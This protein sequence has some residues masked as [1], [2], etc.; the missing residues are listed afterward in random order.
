MAARSR[1]SLALDT[2]VL[3]DLADGSEVA[4]DFREV[5]QRKGYSLAAPPTAMFELAMHRA[6]GDAR[7]QR[8]ADLA[9]TRLAAWRIVP[10]SFSDVE[11]AIADRFAARLIELGLLPEEEFSDGL[12]LAE[13]A[14]ARIPVVVSS[15]KHL[16]DIEPEDLRAALDAADLEQVTVM[17]PHKLLRAVL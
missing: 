2:N 4:H 8:L 1:K 10:L 12:I 16:L 7:R 9:L 17:H 3:L 11:A 13:A 5:F 6:S 15:D 14:L